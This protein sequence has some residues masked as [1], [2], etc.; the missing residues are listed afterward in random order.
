MTDPVPFGSDLLLLSHVPYLTGCSLSPLLS[1]HL[2][3]FL[4]TVTAVPQ[5]NRIRPPCSLKSR[6][7]SYL[8]YPPQSGAATPQPCSSFCGI[9]ELSLASATPAAGLSHHA[10]LSALATPSEWSRTSFLCIARWYPGFLLTTT[11]PTLST[12]NKRLT[13]HCEEST[14][15]LIQFPAALSCNRTQCTILFLPILWVSISLF[16]SVSLGTVITR[17]SFI[18]QTDSSI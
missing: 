4:L 15:Y 12:L 9:L 2:S 8:P 18:F 3:C 14:V 11:F 10:L 13:K 5:A 7:S 17:A 1:S 6:K 16:R